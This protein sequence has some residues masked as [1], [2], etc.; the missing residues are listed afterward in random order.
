LTTSPA[1]ADVEL[2][3]PEYVAATCAWLASWATTAPANDALFHFIRA[4]KAHD[5]LRGL[6]AGQAHAALARIT[7][8]GVEI[9]LPG[10][11]IFDGEDGE[12]AFHDI[13]ERVRFAADIDPV[14]AACELAGK[15]CI[16]TQVDRPGRFGRFLT[17]AALLQM[18]MGQRPIML[19]VHKLAEFFPCQANTVS[20][21]IRW[22]QEDGVLIRTRRH[23]FRSE[24]ESRAA[25]YLLGLHLWKPMLPKLAGLLGISIDAEVI[26]WIN[27]EFQRRSSTPAE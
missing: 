27:A 13:W 20:S 17:I 16:R 9:D 6:P 19:P 14:E 26:A 18:Q 21:W 23:A 11:D 25:E 10:V 22:A 24:G 5:S 3:L 2:T 15:G 8:S 1:P 12:V 4:M 7:A